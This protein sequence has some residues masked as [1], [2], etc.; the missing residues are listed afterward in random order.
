M[1]SQNDNSDNYNSHNWVGAES[2]DPKDCIIYCRDCG[3]ENLGDPADIDY[4]NC[5]DRSIKS[6]K[7]FWAELYK[8]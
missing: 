8:L 2:A 7:D 6:P 4:P 1:L 5:V 3:T